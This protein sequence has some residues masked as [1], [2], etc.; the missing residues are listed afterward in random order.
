MVPQNF[1]GIDRDQQ[2]ML[3]PDLREWLPADHLAWFVIATVDELDLS[4]FYAAYRADGHGRAAFD[5]G[6][7]VALVL[8]AYAVGERSSRRI[9]RHCVQDVAFR[10]VAANQ[11]PDHSTIARFVVRHDGALA[12]LFG[13]VLG[14][15]SRAGL[16]S[17]GTVALD[18][19]KVAADASMSANR[20]Y[21]QIAREIIQEG[22]RTDEREDA[23]F[24]ERRGDELP[25]ELVDPVSRRA[26]LREIKRQLEAEREAEQQAH[27]DR[28]RA[29]A[30]LEAQRGRKL[31]GSKPKAPADHVDPSVKRNMTDP[32]SRLMRAGGGGFVQGYNAQAVCNE[33]QVI[34]AAEIVQQSGDSGLLEPM[35]QHTT[36]ELARAGITDP[37]DTVLADA[38]YW[39]REQIQQLIA[40]GSQVLV[41]PDR[42]LGRPSTKPRAKRDEGLTRFMRS[43]LQRPDTKALYGLRQQLIEPIFGDLKHNRNTR[44]FRRRGL[45]ACRTEWRLLAATN[46]LLKLHRA[47]P[48]TG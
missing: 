33:H 14:L 18:G 42:H 15:C 35:I 3:P 1:V 8:Y 44:R 21:E 10:V 38:G 47:H 17:V 22:I 11:A 31:P 29:R 12:E 19:T 27:R 4:G 43:V 45:A 25:P 30:E 9:E 39:D 20:S 2:L 37:P 16:A 7:M 48:A 34:L 40:N 26:R 5:P 41:P 46:N 32:D 6:L 24:G 36:R 13:Q 28:L 23:L